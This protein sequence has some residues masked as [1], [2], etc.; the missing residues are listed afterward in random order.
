MNG[1][2]VGILEKH[3]NGAHT[4]QYGKSWIANTHTRPLSL[5]LKLQIP[6]ITSDAVINYFDNLLP[7]SSHV[8]DRIVARYKASSK[9]PFDLLK[10]IGKDSVGAI[11]LL[12]PERPYKKGPL[13]Y[14][15]LDQRK[16]ETVLS[17]YKSDIPLGMLEEEEDFRISVAGVQEKTA[18]LFAEG[19]WCMPKGNTPT[20]H[21]IKLPIGEIQQAN[22]TLD[23]K[24]SVENEYL[25]I[26]LARAMGF[27]VPNIDI[28][29]TDNIKALAVERFDRRWTIDRARLLRLPQEDIC[30]AF[31]VPSSIKYESQGGPGIAQIMELLMGSSNAIEDRYNFMRF[32][33][34]QWLIG[35]TDGHAK[36]FSIYLE[37]GGSY[38]LTPFYD[39]LS[40]Y[41]L[42]GGKGL[43]IRKLKLAMGL[44]AT[45]GKKYEIS[46]ILPR[47]FLDT[48]KAVNF[49]QDVMQKIL[50]EMKDGLP[51]AILKVNA[52]LPD[53]FPKH[54]ADSIFENTH[55]IINKI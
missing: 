22:A 12:P 19:R 44:K 47:H 15:V 39:I 53:D 26:E 54:I 46:K 37:Q 8:R 11:A 31:G 21:I 55:K 41:P 43:N 13:S 10:E 27:A 51:K 48:A 2:F 28:I 6:P 42:L 50:D 30:Q 23:L 36:N 40:A 4:F 1:E 33:V 25:C 34:F 5:S 16:L 24:D 20:T 29:K 3:K 35:A 7:D 49:S 17:A 18:L 38:R 32:Q 9:Q 45:K 14:D 52:E